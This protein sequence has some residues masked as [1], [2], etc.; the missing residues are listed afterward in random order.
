MWR[1]PARRDY[2]YFC[3]Q[4]VAGHSCRRAQLWRGDWVMKRGSFIRM[5]LAMAI[6]ASCMGDAYGQFRPNCGGEEQPPCVPPSLPVLP[7]LNPQSKS[8]NGTK[9]L[10]IGGVIAIIGIT[11]TLPLVTNTSPFV[12]NNGPP[13]SPTSP[14]FGSPPGGPSGPGADGTPNQPPPGP[15]SGPFLR[16]TFNQPAR[17]ADCVPDEVIA[18]AL[19]DQIALIAA[20]NN[21]TVLQSNFF[22][23]LDTWLHLLHIE[24]GVPV[25]TAITGLSGDTQARGAQCNFYF[26]TAQAPEEPASAAEQYAP[27]K[28]NLTEAHRLARGDRILIAVIDSGVD[29][30]HPD[31][32]GAI[33]GVFEAAGAGEA[34]H[35]HG[36]G[37]AG[38][39]AARRNMLGTAPGVRLLAVRAFSSRRTAQRAPPTASS[40]GLTGRRPRAPA[41]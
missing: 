6:A 15:P 38:A 28:L 22:P 24:G 2:K 11:V 33:A 9:T 26:R 13:A 14:S 12:T 32:A 36:T 35:A 37:M 8:G 27:A 39:I 21:L 20:R 23:L 18:D 17:A 19:P 10:V 40:G 16:S 3:D 4:P 41:W 31:L 34:A 30:S 5:A 1:D 7:P 29:T 25:T